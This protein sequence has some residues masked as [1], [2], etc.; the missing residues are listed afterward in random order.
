VEGNIDGE[1][2]PHLQHDFMDS[3]GTWEVYQNPYGFRLSM[4]KLGK[5]C[6]EISIQKRLLS[7]I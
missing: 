6:R 1:D 5:S 2:D 7:Q 3:G 4:L